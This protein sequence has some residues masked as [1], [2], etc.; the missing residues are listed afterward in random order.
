MKFEL[1]KRVL[2]LPRE[3]D[4]YA[5]LAVSDRAREILS[6][7]KELNRCLPF[8]SFSS[9]AQTRRPEISTM[10]KEHEKLYLKKQSYDHFHSILLENG[11]SDTTAGQLRDDLLPLVT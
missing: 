11:P 10:P 6:N 9:S 3:D 1:L 8:P 5:S 2:S 4:S 7:L